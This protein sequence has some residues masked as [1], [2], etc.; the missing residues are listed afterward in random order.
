MM[1][2]SQSDYRS[3][4]PVARFVVAGIVVPVVA[5]GFDGHRPSSR[6]DAPLPSPVY[7]DARARD[8]GSSDRIAAKGTDAVEVAQ[9][10]RDLAAARDTYMSGNFRFFLHLP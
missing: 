10:S 7:A 9:P 2:A 5:S 3:R 8:A 6:G 1:L 4:F